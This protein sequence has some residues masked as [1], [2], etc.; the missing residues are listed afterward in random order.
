MRER[1]RWRFS[2]MDTGYI[3]MLGFQHVSCFHNANGPIIRECVRGGD[4]WPA[5]AV[6]ELIAG[7]LGTNQK[8]NYPE[9]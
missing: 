4:E 5:G 6:K 9:F 1:A 7:D 2:V 3:Y 8:S